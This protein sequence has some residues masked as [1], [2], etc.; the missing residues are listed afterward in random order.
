MPPSAPTQAPLVSVVWN[1]SSRL[2]AAQTCIKALTDGA[3]SHFEIVVQA[4]NSTD[5]TLEE[6]QKAAR[7]DPRIRILP[8][9][10]A[11]SGAGLLTSMRA[12][13]GEYIGIWPM[14][15]RL[16]PN[17]IEVAVNEFA[18]RPSVGAVCGN[19]FLIDGH[20]SSL[21]SVDI[22][23]LL[24]TS[25]Q[26]FLPGGFFRR[27]ALQECGLERDGW[28]TEA[29]DLDL[30]LHLATDFGIH[31]ILQPLVECPNP[32]ALNDG[33][34]MNAASAI[35]ERM[36]ILSRTFSI[37]G[38]FG[39]IEALHL[40]AVVNHL[41]SLWQR[42]SALGTRDADFLCVTHSFCRQLLVMPT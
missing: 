19:G 3:Y 26:P 31:S 17:A 37:E 4:G 21:A 33:L 16:L 1:G 29:I 18:K 12:C 10:A 6:F 34:P 30:C 15:G 13:R 8:M 5:G 22:V 39:P 42:L 27:R 14:H 11:D 24:F 40:E 35:E 25:Y 38:F 32:L 2:E 23:T 7:G 36:R 28:L 20:G 9:V 41:S